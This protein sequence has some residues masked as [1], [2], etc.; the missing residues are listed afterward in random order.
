LIAAQDASGGIQ[1]AT[2]F[3]GQAGD[4]PAALPEVRDVIHVVG[5][6]DKAFRYLA[7]HVETA[8]PAGVSQPFATTCTVRGRRLEL[9][10]T[11]TLVEVSD[12]GTVCYRWRKGRPWAEV[13][14]MAFWFR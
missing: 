11:P 4:R 7:A 12:Q 1:T 5:W 13:A 10:E 3:G 2:G 14:S 8:L 6:C 9:L